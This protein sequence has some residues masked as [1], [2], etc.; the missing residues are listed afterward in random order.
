MAD[1][2]SSCKRPVA[3]VLS[4]KLKPMPI[5]PEP[6][7]RGN[8]R[9]GPGDPPRATVVPELERGQYAGQLYISHFATCPFAGEHRR[10]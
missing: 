8:L 6:S 1:V 4:A 5:D 3:W 7:E 10:R 9:L 2:C